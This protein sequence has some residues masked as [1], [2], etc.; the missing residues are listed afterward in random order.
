MDRFSFR[1]FR[2][3]LTSLAG[4]LGLL[5]LS[6]APVPALAASNHQSGLVN[7]N[8]QDVAVQVPVSVAVPIGVAANVCD[9]DAAVLAEQLAAGPADCTAVSNSQALSMAVAQAMTS[10]GGGGGASNHQSG[11]VNVNIQDLAIQIPV[12]VAVPIG[13]AANV[14]DVNAAILASQKDLGGATCTATSTSTAL[15]QAIAGAIV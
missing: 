8:L 7:V 12:S 1:R 6:L 5:T 3:A 11:L 9:V 13:V 4:A 14:C 2:I 10:G 15:T